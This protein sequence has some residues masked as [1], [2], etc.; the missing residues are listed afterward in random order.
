MDLKSVT[1][2]AL[3]VMIRAYTRTLAEKFEGIRFS[4]ESLDEQLSN[5]EIYL[6]NPNSLAP[7]GFVKLIYK[8]YAL[9]VP[10]RKVVVD[11]KTKMPRV[12]VHP[13]HDLLQPDKELPDDLLTNMEYYLRILSASSGVLHNDSKTL[14]MTDLI[15]PTGWEIKHK[16]S[17]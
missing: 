16:T 11:G 3:K 6:F 17:E 8:H 2:P 4:Y 13:Q 1:D 15:L 14:L 9:I 10:V 7:K 5:K 12:N